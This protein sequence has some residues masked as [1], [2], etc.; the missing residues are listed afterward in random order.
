V[1]RNGTWYTLESTRGFRITQFG[2][3]SDIPVPGDY[4]GDGAADHAVFRNGTWYMLSATSYTVK[5]HGQASDIPVP[6]DYDGD[7]KYDLAVF[8]PSAGRWY[9][10]KSSLD[11]DIPIELGTVGDIAIPSPYWLLP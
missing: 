7:G 6:A 4:D 11:F 2:Q 9:I 1:F 10:K 5:Q 8:R 3:T